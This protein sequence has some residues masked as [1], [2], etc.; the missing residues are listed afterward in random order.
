MR[1]YSHSGNC[2]W[3]WRYRCAAQGTS[4]K[5]AT[6]GQGEPTFK[7]EEG[8]AVGAV[9]MYEARYRRASLPTRTRRPIIRHKVQK[10][11]NALGQRFVQYRKK[12]PHHRSKTARQSVSPKPA[13][14]RKAGLR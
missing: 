10:S 14:I 7:S 2:S 12:T 4:Q 5:E 13:G 3:L 11:G 6:D 9:G 1:L 8:I